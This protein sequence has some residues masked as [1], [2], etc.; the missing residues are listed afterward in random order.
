[1]KRRE[2]AILLLIVALAAVSSLRAQCTGPGCR[3]P[4]APHPA[5]VRI[6]NATGQSRSYGSGT[7]VQKSA[8]QGII[9]TCAHLFRDGV[10]SV[11]VAF[12][13]GRQYAG[14]VL[15]VDGA[16][17]LAAIAVAEPVGEPVTVAAS[18][19]RPGEVLQSCGYGP[20]G[21]YACNR[22]QALG[23]SRTASTPT[24]ETLEWTG[25]AREGDSGGPVFNLRGELA[26]VLWGTDGRTVSGTYCGR[27]RQFLAGI[28]TAG[29]AAPPNAVAPSAPAPAVRPPGA[30]LPGQQPPAEAEASWDRIRQRLDLLADQ[31]EAAN[32]RQTDEGDRLKRRIEGVEKGISLLAGLQGRIERAEAAVGQENLRR[33]VREVATGALADRG[34]TLASTLLPAV[35]AALGWTGPPAAALVIGLR[36]LAGLLRRRAARRSRPKPQEAP[37][38]EDQRAPLNDEYAEQLARVYALSGRSPMADATLGREY[39]EELR[40]AAASSDPRLAGWARQLRERVAQKFYRIHGQS[41]APAEPVGK[42]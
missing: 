7:L 11:A 17:D 2:P 3:A 26:A 14:R 21:R 28:V 37:R 10:G 30:P 19:P 16:W 41:P 42:G 25:S 35:L 4:A 5:V 22:G 31:M 29:G 18:P 36:I 32:R 34:P 40:Q 13:D 39:D 33:I 20:D 38:R 9:V 24:N 6:V 23:Y 27:I 15:A 1:M 8:G 12:A